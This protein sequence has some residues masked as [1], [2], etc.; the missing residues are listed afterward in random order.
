VAAI[1]VPSQWRFEPRGIDESFGA[2]VYALAAAGALLLLRSAY[3]MVSVALAGWQLRA[4]TALPRVA[5]QAAGDTAVVGQP[6][7][8]CRVYEV[9]GLMGVS[10]AGVIRPRILVGPAVRETLTAA[11][12]D[13]AV[14]H[15]VAHRAARDNMKRFVMLCAPDFFGQTAAARA[16]ENQWRAA[17]EWQADAHAVR[18]D[19]ARAV[20]LASALVKVARIAA[21]A[22]ARLT[23]PA[24][25]TLHEAPLLES[26]VRRL[27]DSTVPPAAVPRSAWL[28]VVLAGAA[29]VVAAGVAAGA[30]VHQF[31]ET[32]A[33]LI[34]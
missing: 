31:A 3:R 19:E 6:L 25:S 11:E 21:V 34:P 18:G 15:E 17:A 24:W 12:L 20:N 10:L 2:G 14:A 4:C 1:F 33:H 23:S 26:R 30:E 22:P 27:V 9:P 7:M 28:R 16:I 29:V 32:V 8:G 5:P 13:A